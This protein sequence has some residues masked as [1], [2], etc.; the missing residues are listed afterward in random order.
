M[1]GM[2]EACESGRC[3]VAFVQRAA[4][5]VDRDRDMQPQMPVKSRIHTHLHG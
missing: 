5:R 2:R 4:A 3:H 1:K